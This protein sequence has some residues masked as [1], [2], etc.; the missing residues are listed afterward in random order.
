LLFFLAVTLL[1]RLMV[2]N[3]DESVLGDRIE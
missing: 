1:E 3:W 2:G